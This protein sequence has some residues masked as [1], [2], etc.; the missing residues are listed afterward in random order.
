MSV[1]L[2]GLNLGNP[3]IKY[4]FRF[5]CQHVLPLVYDDSLSYYELLCKCVKYINGLHEDD[6]ALADEIARIERETNLRIDE[7]TTALNNA[8]VEI[9]TRIDNEVETLQ[10]NINQVDTDSRNRD[11]ALGRRIDNLSA[12]M[13]NYI[14]GLL[15]EWASDGTLGRLIDREV[16]NKMISKS[17]GTMLNE[18]NEPMT[19]L[20][21]YITNDVF[22]IIRCNGTYQIVSKAP[23]FDIDT[24]VNYYVDSVNGQDGTGDGSFNNPWRNLYKAFNELSQLENG[25]TVTLKNDCYYSNMSSGGLSVGN[26]KKI[27]VDGNGYKIITSPLYATG[28]TPYTFQQYNDEFD[29]PQPRIYYCDQR[30]NIKNVMLF[31]D[32]EYI[33]F[34]QV[35]TK[36]DLLAK[37]FTYYYFLDVGTP[38]LMIHM[39]NDDTPVVYDNI[40]WTTHSYT[41][42]LVSSGGCLEIRNLDIIGGYPCI[43]VTGSGKFY[44]K[45]LR[46]LYS[47][48]NGLQASGQ[49]GESADKFIQLENCKSNFNHDDGF[50]YHGAGLA[51]EIN[52]VA[53][54]NGY[55]NYGTSSNP[56]NN[57]NG[58]TIH[59]VFRIMRYKTTCYNNHG[60][61]IVDV[62][63]STST[64]YA[65]NC[66]YSCADTSTDLPNTHWN[67]N[68]AIQSNEATT[69]K[70]YG[71]KAYG[72]EFDVGNSSPNATL[73]VNNCWY[74][75]TY[76]TIT[77]Q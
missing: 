1:E 77:E 13:E 3:T 2:N 74:D 50:N 48:S 71:C 9:N 42:F 10:Q 25:G 24:T 43:A 60:G 16:Y 15:D 51:V 23:K 5:W 67:T 4:P 56:I 59:D 29:V 58:S 7:L 20:G 8:V 28:T 57:N 65:C 75:T 70:L 68:F 18:V 26:G 76:G 62:G 37:P 46:L 6:I 21:E 73:T 17:F 14:D 39:P 12:D 40:F 34:K 22:P 69:M 19:Q 66:Y 31:N 55:N 45:N 61:N 64:N 32:S 63:E 30:S 52:C 41:P 33:P 49:T 11:T 44:G 35:S 72:S 53:H 47:A 27:R 38:I 54:D 36:A